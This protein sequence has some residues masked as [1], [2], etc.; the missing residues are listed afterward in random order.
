MASGW[1]RPTP[2]LP[3]TT[4]CTGCRTTFLRC[5]GSHTL[6]FGASTHWDKVDIA[7]PNNASNGAF[8]F[9]GEETGVDYADMLIGAPAYYYQGTPAVLN[10]RN[11][12]VGIYGQDS[13]RVNTHLVANLG[14]RWDVDPFWEDAH[15]ASPVVQL[16]IQST[17]YPTAPTGYVFPGDAGVAR[18]SGALT[19]FNNFG[20]RISLAYTPHVDDGFMHSIFGDEGKSSIRAGFGMYY[21]NVEGA[22]TFNFS[23]PPT[24]L[25]YDNSAPVLFEKP[26]LN[27]DSGVSLVQRFPLPPVNP[28]TIDWSL[29]EPLGGN[30]NP[31]RISK[32]PYSEHIDLSFER[33]LAANMVFSV[34]L[35]WYLRPPPDRG[36]QQQP[37][38]SS[39]LSKCQ[40][41]RPDDGWRH[42]RAGRREQRLSP[43]G[44]RRHQ[45]YTWAFRFPVRRQSV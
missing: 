43:G 24:H 9:S 41:T 15:N 6:K 14:L 30:S 11:Y 44:R 10:L 17:Q 29:Y 23:A 1:V 5:I 28:S 18:R 39:S 16:G 12:Y 27:R 42:L 7:H 20:P 38:R 33:E 32:T 4:T 21:T 26:F 2:F 37:G 31:L 40:S 8:G 35:R 25:F 3:R 13:W 45:W 19:R 22:N 34:S 36:R